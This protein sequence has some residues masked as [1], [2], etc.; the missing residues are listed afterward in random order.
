[1]EILLVTHSLHG[2]P[3]KLHETES[4]DTFLISR[5]LREKDYNVSILTH[6]DFASLEPEKLIGRIILYASSQYPELFNCI[7][8]YLLYALSC[9]CNIIPNFNMFRSHENKFFQELVK[10]RLGINAPK[11]WLVGTMED[12]YRY[13]GELSFPL[14]FKTSMGFGSSGVEKIDNAKQLISI[15][16]NS[17]LPIHQRPNNL[18]RRLKQSKYHDEKILLYKDKY[19]SHVGRIILQEYLEGLTY[20][21]KILVFGKACF[22]LKRYVRND[23]FRASGSGKFTFDEV[24]SNSLLDFALNVTKK[25]D[26]PWASLDIAKYKNEYKLIEYQCVHFGMYTLMRNFRYFEKVDGEWVSRAVEDASPEQFMCNALL[27]YINCQ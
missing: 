17:L 6:G 20:D 2:I 7:E 23:D 3:Q 8:D 21:W 26:T 10:K 12:L 1:M 11:S 5:I 14:V 4:L 22:C 9:G 24:P 27:G 16:K 13:I 15:T 19:P 25:L 18:L